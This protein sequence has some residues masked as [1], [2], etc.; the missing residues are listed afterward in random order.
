M[1]PVVGIVEQFLQTFKAFPPTQ[2]AGYLRVENTSA[3][4]LDGVRTEAESDLGPATR[5]FS[6]MRKRV[7]S[8]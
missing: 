5:W 7:A 3:Q 4:T 8:E 6:E 1:M 2:V